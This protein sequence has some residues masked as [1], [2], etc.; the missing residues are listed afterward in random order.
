MVGQPN[1]ARQKQLD[2]NAVEVM[3]VERQAGFPVLWVGRHFADRVNVVRVSHPSEAA[4]SAASDIAGW[5]AAITALLSFA[6]AVD[7]ADREAWD[8]YCDGDDARA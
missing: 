2:F 1:W 5:Q 4:P 6:W 3:S 8:A 7:D